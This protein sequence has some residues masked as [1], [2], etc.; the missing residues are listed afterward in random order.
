LTFALGRR[1]PSGATPV[2]AVSRTV[3]QGWLSDLHAAGL[4]PLAMYP[5]ISLMPENPGQTVLWLEKERLAVRRPGALPFAV[6]LSPMSEALVVAG[7]IE[8]NLS[9]SSAPF[10]TKLAVGLATICML[11]G[12]L[13]LGGRRQP[14][15]PTPAPPEGASQP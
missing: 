5:D 4:E 6:E 12:W 2:A 8:G 3:L 11:Y 1:R 15:R 7:V 14:D 9:P 13:L 10:A